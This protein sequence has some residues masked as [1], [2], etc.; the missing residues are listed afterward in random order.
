VVNDWIGR[1]LARGR[2][3]AALLKEI[4][5]AKAAVAHMQQ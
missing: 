1:T 4:E 2:L 3:T 5:G